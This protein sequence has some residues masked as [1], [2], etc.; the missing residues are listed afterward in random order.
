MNKEDDIKDIIKQL[1]D[2]Q[3]KQNKLLARLQE[4]VEASEVKQDRP[5]AIGDT[6]TIKNPK[7]FQERRGRIT[8]L[9]E[10]KEGRI[11]VSTP[12]G[13]NIIRAPKNLTLE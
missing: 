4:K 8:R 5:F 6:V 12:T 1:S 3:L 11:T 10:G 13:K 7:P 2:L 9:G